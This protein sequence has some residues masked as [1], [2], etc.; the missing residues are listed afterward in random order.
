MVKCVD[1]FEVGMNTY[2]LEELRLQR[3]K[4]MDRVVY[5]VS[6]LGMVE[7]VYIADIMEFGR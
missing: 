5:T 7:Q 4:G 2:Y 1:L 3:V 6:I